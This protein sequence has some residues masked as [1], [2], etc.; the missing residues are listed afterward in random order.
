MFVYCQLKS[1]TD[2]YYKI[3]DITPQPG[4]YVTQ[5]RIRNQTHRVDSINKNHM[6]AGCGILLTNTGKSPY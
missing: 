2:Y 5:P 1:I 3:N 6:P 4:Q